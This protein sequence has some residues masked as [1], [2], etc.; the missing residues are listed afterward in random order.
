VFVNNFCIEFHENLTKGLIADTSPRTDR[1]TWSP[2][3]AFIS[4]RKESLKTKQLTQQE[5]ISSV[6]SENHTN[7]VTALCGTNVEFM[8]FKPAA[9]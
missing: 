9:T 2:H 4:L 8:N 7:H 6:L 5:E 1:K 3:T